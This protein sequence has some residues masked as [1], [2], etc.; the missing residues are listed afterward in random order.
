MKVGGGGGGRGATLNG[1]RGYPK[2]QHGW[3]WGAWFCFLILLDWMNHFPSLL[4]CLAWLIQNWFLQTNKV[5]QNPIPKLRQTSIISKKPRFLSEKLKTLTSSNYHRVWYFLLKF[6]AR[7][8]LS[9][10]YKSVCGVFL[11]L[12]R[13]WVINKS[14]KNECV[15]IRSFLSF[16][17]NSRSK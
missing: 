9:N 17:N 4:R 5:M 7:F 11:I 12:F 13:S 16:S 1:F 3:I 14:V 2:D 10:A 6:C 8:L 15:E